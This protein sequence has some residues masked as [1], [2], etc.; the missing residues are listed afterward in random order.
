MMFPNAAFTSSVEWHNV[1]SSLPA[2]SIGLTMTLNGV[3]DHEVRKVAISDQVVARHC[4]TARTP[5]SR[6]CSPMRYLLRRDSVSP[7]PLVRT[8]GY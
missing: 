1:T 8:W 4:M 2:L 7:D 3:G 6:T 5:A